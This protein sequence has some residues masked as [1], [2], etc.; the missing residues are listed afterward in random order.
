MQQ[1]NITEHFKGCVFCAGCVHDLCSE[2]FFQV[3]FVSRLP[4]PSTSTSDIILT[5][6]LT[7]MISNVQYSSDKKC[8]INN[9]SCYISLGFVI[10]ILV[11]ILECFILRH[12]SLGCDFCVFYIKTYI[13]GL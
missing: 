1:L 10:Y 11:L 13:T 2:C 3:F 5:N 9:R 8:D 7:K 4:K 6:K 12:I